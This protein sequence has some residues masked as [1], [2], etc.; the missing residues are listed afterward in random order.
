MIPP[1]VAVVSSHGV[2]TSGSPGVTIVVARFRNA[3]SIPALVLVL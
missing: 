3:F 2:V 1:G